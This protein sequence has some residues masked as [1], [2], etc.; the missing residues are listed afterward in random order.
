[1][2]SVIPSSSWATASSSV[3]RLSLIGSL[4]AIHGSSLA[5][6][7]PAGG[8]RPFSNADAPY[9]RA[10]CPSAR[11]RGWLLHE[12]VASFVAHTGQVE[13][14]REALLEPV[15]PFDV[16]RVD[17]VERLLGPADDSRVLG[18]DLCR[19]GPGRGHQLIAWHDV[20]YRP[21]VLQLLR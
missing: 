16:D 6:R 15:T 12:G 4:L 10:S 9:R 1:M 11:S 20:E 2:P 5:G 3:R 21:V 14:K 8:R 7:L 18:R 17:A 13:L 19:H